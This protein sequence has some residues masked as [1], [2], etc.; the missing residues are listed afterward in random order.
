ME[1]VL[2]WWKRNDLKEIKI[3]AERDNTEIKF[4]Y[5][6]RVAKSYV[7][8]LKILLKEYPE[9]IEVQGNLDEY[10]L[11]VEFKKKKEESDYLIFIDSEK[12]KRYISSLP[13]KELQRIFP[14][15]ERKVTKGVRLDVH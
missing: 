13:V 3:Y 1:I 7:D 14:E 8:M 6:H 2:I 9:D 12:E 4:S 5:N 15:I 10:N 11:P